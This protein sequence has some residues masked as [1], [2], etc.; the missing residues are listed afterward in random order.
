MATESEQHLSQRVGLLPQPMPSPKT[1]DTILLN[2]P[3]PAVETDFDANFCQM[4]ASR[5]GLPDTTKTEIPSD[6]R[7]SNPAGR[8]W[9]DP[10]RLDGELELPLQQC[11]LQRSN[12]LRRRVHPCRDLTTCKS[13]QQRWYSRIAKYE[14][15]KDNNTNTN[16]SSSWKAANDLEWGF[17]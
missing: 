2:H 5:Q 4:V 6:A 7:P 14:N 11:G 10:G 15:N 3:S 8:S 16:S 9:P 13:S 17:S 1:I 12:A